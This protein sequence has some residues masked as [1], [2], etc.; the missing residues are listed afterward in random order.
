MRTALLVV[1]SEDAEVPDIDANWLAVGPHADA[2]PTT[3]QLD[4]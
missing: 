4:T 1:D 3:D 2:A